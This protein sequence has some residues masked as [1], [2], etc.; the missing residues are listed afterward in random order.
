MCPSIVEEALNKWV[1]IVS[2]RQATMGGF[3]DKVVD[4]GRDLVY[5]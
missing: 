2:T 5:N 1:H 3:E 4:F